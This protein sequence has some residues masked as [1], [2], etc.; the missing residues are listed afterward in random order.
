MAPLP[1]AKMQSLSSCDFI[2][3]V[4]SNYFF[5]NSFK[6]FFKMTPLD[7][8]FEIPLSDY[9]L[10]CYNASTY[11]PPTPWSEEFLYTESHP[12]MTSIG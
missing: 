9:E 11:P 7:F 6:F 5:L 12:D 2:T 4:V 8:N 3:S 1:G 10:D